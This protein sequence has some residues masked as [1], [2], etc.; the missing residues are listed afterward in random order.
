M[1]TE[2]RVELGLFHFL[3][4]QRVPV[5]KPS[6][7]GVLP[8]HL[9]THNRTNHRLYSDDFRTKQS[10][11]QW[12]QDVLLPSLPCKPLDPSIDD[13]PVPPPDD[14]ALTFAR[15]LACSS[16]LDGMKSNHGR[17]SILSAICLSYQNVRLGHPMLSCRGS[18]Q[19][20]RF[21]EATSGRPRSPSEVPKRPHGRK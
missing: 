9:V 11:T 2:D 17:F 21:D 5:C 6:A 4:D 14:E 19:H 3:Q 12:V 20:G 1:S 7:A 10:T 8:K 16:I 13:L 18:R 15:L